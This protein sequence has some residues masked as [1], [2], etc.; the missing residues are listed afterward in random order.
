MDKAC[1][2]LAFHPPNKFIIG[3]DIF[4]CVLCGSSSVVGHCRVMLLLAKSAPPTPI[5][6]GGPKSQ[7]YR[8]WDR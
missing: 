6:K 5:K 2:Y 7:F 1:R 8:L 4:F 3:L